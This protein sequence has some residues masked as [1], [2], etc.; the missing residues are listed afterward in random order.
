[1]NELFVPINIDKCHILAL[2]IRITLSIKEQM[3]IVN[4]Q[5]E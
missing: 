4:F 5:I 2:K 3:E 1:M